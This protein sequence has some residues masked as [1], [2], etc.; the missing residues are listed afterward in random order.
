MTAAKNKDV[1]PGMGRRLAAFLGWLFWGPPRGVMWSVVSLVAFAGASFGLWRHVRPQVL[2]G[3]DYQL[4]ARDVEITPLPSW[5]HSDLAG[6]VVRS[7]SLDAPLSVLD[8]DL[9]QR[10]HDAFA[11]QPWVA[12]VQR[13][14]KQHPARVRVDLIY[15]RPVCMV[16]TAGGPLPGSGVTTATRLLPVDAHG[17]LLPERDFI[18]AQREQYPRLASIPTLP[19]SMAGSRWPDSRVLGGAQ[20]AAALV[21]VWKE[22]SMQRIVASQQPDPKLPTPEYTYEIFTTGGT[23]ILWGHAPDTR[24]PGIRPVA[25]KLKRI[26][27][28]QDLLD[29]P[30]GPQQIDVE[31]WREARVTPGGVR[32]TTRPEGEEGVAR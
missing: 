19:P 32:T 5:I 24:M 29:G 14:S 31:Y 13:V 28:Y 21:D 6:D 10:I 30:D 16:E 27:Q 9:T 7:L 12:K 1:A 26:K 20:I 4:S 23:R 17:I 8:D 25:E 22:F 11:A 2:A 18:P 15:R 3:R